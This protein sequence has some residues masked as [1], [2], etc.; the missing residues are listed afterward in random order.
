VTIIYYLYKDGP[1]P[2]SP[3]AADVA[4][5]DGIDVGDAVFLIN[6]IFKGGALPESVR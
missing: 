6:Y 2:V 3:E 4:G 1:V 5:D